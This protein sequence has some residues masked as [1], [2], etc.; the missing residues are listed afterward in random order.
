MH[1]NRSQIKRNTRPFVLYSYLNESVVKV[2]INYTL[3][4]LTL[5]IQISF[6]YHSPSGPTA[7][8][9]VQ[10]GGGWGRG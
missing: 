7:D 2:C 10:L 6:L 5:V 3:T 4:E 8:R 1:K 9:Q